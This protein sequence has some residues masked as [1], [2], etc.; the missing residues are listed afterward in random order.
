[1]FH[2]PRKKKKRE[3][4]EGKHTIVE[5][6]ITS[7]LSQTGVW[8]NDCSTKNEIRPKLDNNLEYK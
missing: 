2:K 8:A 5:K 3:N 1:M 4:F 6:S 7:T